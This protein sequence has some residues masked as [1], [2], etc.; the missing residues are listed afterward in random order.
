MLRSLSRK[1]ATHKSLTFTN[2]SAVPPNILPL[3]LTSFSE[4]GPPSSPARRF[5]KP[6]TWCSLMTSIIFPRMASIR[7]SQSPA[8]AVLCEK[9]QSLTSPCFA[10]R[11]VLQAG[12]MQLQ[13]IPRLTS[14]ISKKSP[15]SRWSP[16][17]I[18]NV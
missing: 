7:P 13:S 4:T 18:P 12:Q 8:T 3:P 15:D 2:R 5:G 1:T 17:G 9:C 16:N 11:S 6:R 14:V 10:N